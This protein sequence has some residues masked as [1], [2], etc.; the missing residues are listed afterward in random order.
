M[1]KLRFGIIGM[2]NMGSIHAQNFAQ[3]KI[4]NGVVTCFCDIAQSRREYC[5]KTYPDIPV[6]ATADE[7]F[8]SK[9]ADAVIVAVPHYDHVPVAVKAFESGLA[10]I[11]EKPAS[12]TTKAVLEMN[13]AAKK[14][15]KLFGI[16]FNQRTNPAYQKLR[17]MVKSGELGRIR[18]IQ[19][20]ITD[21]YRTQTYHDSAA[22]RSTWATEGG[23]ALINQNPHQLDL[24]QWIFGMPDRIF[25][26][27]SFGKWRNIE[28]EDEAMIY[29][30]YEDGKTATYITSTTETPGTNRLEI[31]CDMGRVVMENNKIVFDKLKMSE[32]EFDKSNKLVFVN[33][34]KETIVYEGFDLGPAHV[35]IVND[36]I[37]AY[38]EGTPLLANGFEGINEMTI[39]NAA[40]YSAWT[41]KWADIKN[42]PHEEFAVLLR[43]KAEN[44]KK[45]ENVEAKVVD[46][47]GTY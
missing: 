36:F 29:W 20:T 1:E 6:F 16:M 23:G 27:C 10:V 45:K 40:H 35:G 4:E 9:L 17:D 22:W 19:W 5:Q 33:P 47:N 34:E 24:M 11:V 15:G 41:G 14:S 37:K 46:I 21:W 2:G 7:L 3:G 26:R 12:V 44:S 18:R 13:E 39:S 43:E 25:A 38:F 30:E 42:F 31:A 32:P 8:A 28:V